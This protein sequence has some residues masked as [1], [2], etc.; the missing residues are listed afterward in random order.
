MAH[1]GTTENPFGRV[2]EQGYYF[3]PDLDAFYV[4]ARVYSPTVA[5]WT[6]SDVLLIDPPDLFAY[7]I[8]SP[9]MSADPSGMIV[10]ET[11]EGSAAAFPGVRL[12]CPVT[13]LAQPIGTLVLSCLYIRG[14]QRRP[15]S[16]VAVGAHFVRSQMGRLVKDNKTTISNDGDAQASCFHLREGNST[17]GGRSSATASCV[18]DSFH[19]IQVV[20]T[21]WPSRK[22]LAVI[23]GSYLDDKPR[24]RPFFDVGLNA[25]RKGRPAAGG[26]SAKCS[27]PGATVSFFDKPTRYRGQALTREPRSGD[28]TWLATSCLVCVRRK[29]DDLVLGCL[30]W[31]FGR[32]RLQGNVWGPATTIGPRCSDDPSPEF[33][34]VLNAYQ[35]YKWKAG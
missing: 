35:Q 28:L 25:G 21:N 3:D 33:E 26:Y 17:S 22:A 20:T 23:D 15:R 13:C 30:Y 34:R 31:G 2:G 1:T 5:R 24:A 8:N 9:L 27:L 29:A 12:A 19:F 32:K 6:S 7:A 4:R 10:T 11:T 18:C 14:V 16:G